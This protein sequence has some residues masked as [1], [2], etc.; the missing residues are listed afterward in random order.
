VIVSFDWQRFSV[1]NAWLQC[2]ND[3]RTASDFCPLSYF[4]QDRVKSWERRLFCCCK[5][6]C[7]PVQ[8][9][10]NGKLQHLYTHGLCLSMRGLMKFCCGL[11]GHSSAGLVGNSTVPADTR[12][13]MR[14]YESCRKVGLAN[15]TP[16][17]AAIINRSSRALCSHEE[18]KRSQRHER[19][20][21][22][23]E[24]SLTGFLTRG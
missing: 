17:F 11:S 9:K 24:T 2:R 7:S 6:S 23:T 16:C 3:L 18:K 4:M 15:R 14:K 1:L 12:M 10:L 8:V 13:R 20:L 5:Y 22:A 19:L 21:Y